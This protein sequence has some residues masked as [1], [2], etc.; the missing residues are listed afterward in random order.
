MASLKGVGPAFIKKSINE[1]SF[2][3]PDYFYEIKTITNLNNKPFEDEA[4]LEAIEFSERVIFDCKIKGI[5]IINVLNPDY[6]IS[7]KEIKDAPAVFFY[8]GNFDLLNKKTISII[9]T[10][11]PNVNG[12]IIAERIG[13]FFSKFNW[14]ICNGLSQGIDSFA[15]QKVNNFN[16]VIGVLGGGLNFDTKK[17]INKKTAENAQKIL[18]LNGLLI[19]E[20]FPDKK[21]DTFSIVKSCRIQSGLSHGLILVQSS[22]TGGSRFAVKSFCETQRPFGIIKPILEDYLI[23]EYEANRLIIENKKSGIAKFTE[24][25]E[26]KIETKSIFVIKSREDYSEFESIVKNSYE[27]LSQSNSN[28]FGL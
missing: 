6:P 24:L 20:T 21:E 3:S 23:H 12:A 26:S 18:D 8:K 5:S 2:I 15:I 7:L 1:N 27:N 14:N 19:S 25:N 28:L 9:G 4:I 16:K 10:R 13:T 11:Q 22:I 17:T